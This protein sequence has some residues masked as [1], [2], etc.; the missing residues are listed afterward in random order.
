VAAGGSVVIKVD[1]TAG[2]NAVLGG[3]FLG[4]AGTPPPPPP[5]PP[6]ATLDQPGVKGDWVGVY[7]ADGYDLGGWNGSTDLTVLPTGVT[8][9]IEQGLRYT[10][11]AN[12]G[13]VRALENPGQ[14]ERRATAWYHATEVRVRLNFTSA[15]SGNLHLYAAD[16]ASTARRQTVIVDDGSGPK[17]INLSTAFDGGAWMH[18]PITVAAGGSVVIK[19]DRTAGTNAVLGG[20]FLGGAGTP[21]S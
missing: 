19:V 6:T 7:G 15:Y 18:F 9:T 10:W 20:L 4:G 3:L 21:P 2:T 1:R 13:D 12:A 5:P 17:T 14:T 8:A 16:W 11:T